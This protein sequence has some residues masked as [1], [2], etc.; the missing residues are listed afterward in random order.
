MLRKYYIAGLILWMPL[1]AMSQVPPSP[2]PPANTVAPVAPSAAAAPTTSV[3]AE[4]LPSATPEPE[5]KFSYGDAPY[6]LFYTA[7][8]I[9][10]MKIILSDV[11][12]ALAQQQP[13]VPKANLEVIPERRRLV[14]EPVDLTNYPMFYLAS[15]VYHTP[16]NW[17]VWLEQSGGGAAPAATP[18]PSADAKAPP[19]PGA[20]VPPNAAPA[21]PTID[22]NGNR[23][24]K[25]TPKNNT[26]DLIVTRVGEHEVEFVWRPTYTNFI[27]TR[28]NRHLFAKSDAVRHRLA[29]NPAITYAPGDKEIHFTL[30][31]N[32][33]FVP[34]YF[35]IFEGRVPNPSLDPLSPTAPTP[36][37]E[38]PQTAVEG[39]PAAPAG[40]VPDNESIDSLLAR[41]Q[42]QDEEKAAAA[43]A[44]A[45]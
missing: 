8:Q 45:K 18:E 41:A 16:S 20:P 33:S 24:M 12:T 15:V 3:S 44:A 39:T 40:A 2:I 9:E 13:I 27:A 4:T 36:N 14:A 38:A 19:A 32:Q 30:R 28:T 42:K 7:K 31:E 10:Q 43:K 22:A 23:H 11:E 34:G 37:A 26:G 17:T 1:A 21:A 35:Q 5:N 6:S 25:I 29:L